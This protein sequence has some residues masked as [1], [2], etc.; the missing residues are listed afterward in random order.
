MA[1][2]DEELADVPLRTKTDWPA[3]VRGISIDETDL[4][5]VDGEGRLYWNGKPVEVSQRLTLSWWQE[6]AA[7]I[8][9]AFVIIGAIGSAAQGWAAYNTWACTVGWYAVCPRIQPGLPAK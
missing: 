8:V 7:L 2:R 6:V 3:G 1:T 9:S 5:G 4:L